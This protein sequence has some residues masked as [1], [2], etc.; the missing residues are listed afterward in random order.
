MTK[1]EYLSD[2]R[3]VNNDYRRFKYWYAKTHDVY[4]D[5]MAG[6]LTKKEFIAERLDQLGATGRLTSSKTMARDQILSTYSESKAGHDNLYKRLESIAA[7]DP[8]KRTNT[9][10]GMYDFFLKGYNKEGKPLFKKV[11]VQA[12]RAHRTKVY[13]PKTGMY[14][15]SIDLINEFYEG[16][17]SRREAG[18]K[19]IGSFVEEIFKSL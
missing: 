16:L 2:K 18:E 13:N 9:E 8:G 11:S 10:Q 3:R 7:K 12:F 5:N 19:G 14:E 4:G 6:R 17:K 15:N 1:K